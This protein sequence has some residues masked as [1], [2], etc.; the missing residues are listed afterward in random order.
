MPDRS[1]SRDFFAFLRVRNTSSKV[2]IQQL[3]VK[4]ML[5]LSF[6]ANT[7]RNPKQLFSSKFEILSKNFVSFCQSASLP[8]EIYDENFKNFELIITFCTSCICTFISRVP[9]SVFKTPRNTNDSTFIDFI[10]IGKS[11]Q[12]GFVVK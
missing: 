7:R 4:S 1:V 2:A 11:T 10:L 9:C 12:K 5:V 8:R 6:R 3:K